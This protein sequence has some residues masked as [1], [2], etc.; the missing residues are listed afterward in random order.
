MNTQRTFLLLIVSMLLV[1]ITSPPVEAQSA[2]PIF[3]SLLSTSDGGLYEHFG[4]AVAIHKNTLIVGAP[5]QENSNGEACIYLQENQVWQL[6]TCLSAKPNFASNVRQFGAAVSISEETLIVGA[7]QKNADN[8]G[9]VYIFHYSDNTWNQTAEIL[10]PD[11]VTNGSFGESVSI[12]GDYAVIGSQG[13]GAARDGAVYIY[14]R[15]DSGWG[16]QLKITPDSGMNN[17]RFGAA[18]MLSG[19][20]LII[21]NYEHGRYH[22]G[23]A[24]IYQREDEIWSRQA[25]LKGGTITR[26]GAFGYAIAISQNYAVVGAK[27]EN[28]P[29]NIKTK[30]RGA[31]YVYRREGK[32]WL[33]QAK[34]VASDS[35][36]GD[37]FG[38]AVSISG[39]Y[40]SVGAQKSDTSAGSAYLF[41]NANGLW[42]ELKKLTASDRSHHDNF[43]CAIA[44]SKSN[45]VI[46]AYNKNFPNNLSGASYVYDLNIQTAPTQSEI[47]L[48]NTFITLSNTPASADSDNDGLSDFN[49][50]TILGTDPYSE[51]TDNDGLTD[52]EEVLIYQSDPTTSDSDND[53]LSD[54][55][56][57]VL[58]NSDPLSV[59]SDNDGYS[60]Y[61]EVTELGTNP[62]LVDSDSDGYTDQE[63]ILITNTNPS[64][65]DT[66]GDGLSDNEEL[67]IYNTDPQQADSDGD[68][69]SDGNEVNYYATDPLE[70]ADSPGTPTISTSY[71]PA[72]GEVGTMAFEDEWPLM[73]DYDFNDA[74]FN[75]NIIETKQ[76]GLIKHIIYRILPVARGAIYSNSLRLLI[77]TP[78]SNI[79]ASSIKTQGKTSVL[80]PTADGNKTLFVILEKI[81][82][83]LPPPPGFKMSNTL[84]GSPKV[85]GRH[86]TVTISFNSPID[87][88]VMGAAPYNSFISRMLDNGELLEVHFPGRFP[89]TKASKRQFGLFNDD[90]DPTQD[91]YYQTSD[92]LPWAMIIPSLWHHT[93]ERV[94]LSNGY[95]DILN[96]AATRG[97]KNKTWYKSKRNS[98][99]V[100]DQVPDI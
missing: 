53:G 85:I 30:K 36:K 79:S 74:V 97:K 46:G 2:N 31:T 87:P 66:D 43:G 52:K 54:F 45:F 42:S 64:L 28:D 72:S 70:Q 47:A 95:P 12:S 91:R 94:D 61:I 82:D 59:D 23:S 98:K 100:F 8:T 56:E 75:Y 81:E 33:H 5:G 6:D 89:T 39:D 34:L 14:K 24:Y 58:Y 90:S 63:E 27:M 40:I 41:Y 88:L 4:T 77:N 17:K 16:L 37:H 50:I 60:D 68:G 55:E 35:R 92:N 9:V 69:F 10:N 80:V 32:L 11:A 13:L 76:D 65:A 99:F 19:E 71:S 44:I 78:I 73:G 83:A 51:D 62:A 29:N 96:W 20:Y 67:N 22:E 21:G 93:K 48:H 38:S 7:R 49:E 1:M 25:S 86:Y 18:V 84:S 3:Q 15:S 26:N 57:V